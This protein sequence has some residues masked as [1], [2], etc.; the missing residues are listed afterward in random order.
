MTQM[1]I[2]FKLY[3][4]FLI[5]LFVNPLKDCNF[6]V[7]FVTVKNTLLLVLFTEIIGAYNKNKIKSCRLLRQRRS[8]EHLDMILGSRIRDF[9]T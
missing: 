6:H 7:A 1:Y 2:D 9:S 8:K 4:I 3:L 5:Y